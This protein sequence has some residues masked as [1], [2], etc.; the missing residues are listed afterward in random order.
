MQKL[1]ELLFS[2]EQW[3]Q[4]QLKHELLGNHCQ[5]DYCY[6]KAEMSLKG[7][8]LEAS[9]ERVHESAWTVLLESSSLRIQRFLAQ[10]D[11]RAGSRKKAAKRSAQ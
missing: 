7:L 8:K 10:K 9:V 2:Q 11:G 4:R 5:K 3:H 6:P 1:M